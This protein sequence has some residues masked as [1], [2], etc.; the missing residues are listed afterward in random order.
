[1]RKANVLFGAMLFG[2]IIAVWRELGTNLCKLFG[3]KIGVDENGDDII[4]FFGQ[5]Q[6][7]WTNGYIYPEELPLT[8]ASHNE[9]NNILERTGIGWNA[10]PLYLA[11]G[12]IIGIRIGISLLLGAILFF[13]VLPCCFE[14]DIVKLHNQVNNTETVVRTQCDTVIDRSEKIDGYQVHYDIDGQPGSLRMAQAPTGN[15][16]PLLNGQLVLN[17]VPISTPPATP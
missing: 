17:A 11:F 14:G 13:G 1:M 16:I 7:D 12:G 9:S 15:S 2:G 3:S 6:D 8:I 10:S 4:H 5:T